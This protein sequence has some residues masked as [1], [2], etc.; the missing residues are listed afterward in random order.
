[1]FHNCTFNCTIVVKRNPARIRRD[2]LRAEQHRAAADELVARL[3]ARPKRVEGASDE[4]EDDEKTDWRGVA[5]LDL[6]DSD[7]KP[8]YEDPRQQAW[9]G[10][11]QDLREVPKH[12]AVEALRSLVRAVAGPEL[13]FRASA[14]TTKGE[15]AAATSQRPRGRAWRRSTLS[16]SKREEDSR[17]GCGWGAVSDVGV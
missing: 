9:S 3:E 2:E 13:K 17:I 1:M 11:P 6:E 16:S 8:L 4:E 15:L 12:E 5:Q 7:R 14:E 10:L